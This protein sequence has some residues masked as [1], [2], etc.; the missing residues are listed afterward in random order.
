MVTFGPSAHG[1]SFITR[2]YSGADLECIICIIGYSFKERN[3][4]PCNS[5]KKN[6]FDVLIF[7]ADEIFIF[8]P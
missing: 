8:F 7:F 1:I 2:G 4:G 6:I 3:C 5:L